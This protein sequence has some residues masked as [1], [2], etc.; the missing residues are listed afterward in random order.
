MVIVDQLSTYKWAFPLG[1][2]SAS[3][4]LEVWCGFQAQVER[5]SGQKI[6]FVC[7]DNG[8]E[9]VNQLF[10]DKFKALGITHELAARYTL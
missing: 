2:K 6:K 3:E 8:G 7:S 4:V 10:G 5:Q 9:F 1:S